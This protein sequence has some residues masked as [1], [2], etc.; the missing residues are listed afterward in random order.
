VHFKLPFSVPMKYKAVTELDLAGKRVLIRVDFNVP[1]KTNPD[2]VVAVADDTRIKASLPTINYVLA[3]GG[4]AILVSHLGRPGGQAVAKYSM[5]PVGKHLAVLTG[6]PVIISP[7]VVGA[8]VEAISRS[9]AP[10]EIMLLENVRFEAGETT[11]SAEVSEGL[12]RLADVYVNDAFG[13][14]HRAHASTSG[15]ALLIPE[16]AAGFLMQKELDTL[17]KVT[18]APDHP[19]VAIVGGAKVSDKIGIIE[20]LLEHVDNLLIGG[21]MA[22]TFLKAKGI[23]TGNS[24]TEDDKLDLARDLLSR[25][26]SRIHLP[27]DHICADAFSETATVASSDIQIPSGMMGLDIGPKTIASYS[28]I[29]LKAKTVIWNGP[30]GVFEMKPFS[31]GTFAIAKTL[32]DATKK[33]A[34]TVVGGGDSVAAI[35]TSGLSEKVSHVS[36]GGGAML[37]LL[38]GKVLP[39]VV[40]LGS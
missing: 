39:G 11:N 12:A 21:A 15:A 3:S 22:Y 10:G 2:G 37:E 14:A 9:L 33:G 38:E 31:N 7:E 34:F 8:Q 26:G 30:M 17:K 32:V 23:E 4:S 27:T 1:L 25:A 13:T 24:L 40:A 19:F 36:T 28:S 35:V 18:E 29:I 6:L 16:R 20:S 5:A